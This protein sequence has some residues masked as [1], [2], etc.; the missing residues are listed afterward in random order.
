MATKKSKRKKNVNNSKQPAK[1]SIENLAPPIHVNSLKVTGF[2]MGSAKNGEPLP[3][4]VKHGLTSDDPLFPDI[5]E[6]V[7]RLINGHLPVDPDRVSVD[8]ANCTLVVL[9]KDDSADLW[10]DTAA[11]AF[12]GMTKRAKKA[13]ELVFQ[14]DLA[15][16]NGFD[17]PAVDLQSDDRI[18]CIVRVGW[19]FFLYFDLRTN[20]GLE[21]SALTLELGTLYRRLAY[22]RLY[23]F[24][25]S[26]TDLDKLAAD[27]WFPFAELS[28]EEFQ[29]FIKHLKAGFDISEVG[30]KVIEA[31][32]KERIEALRERWKARPSFASRAGI[33]NAALD[34]YL[35]D[36]YVS[37]IKN[38]VTEIEGLL[39][40]HFGNRKGKIP[41]LIKLAEGAAISKA[42]APDTI[43]LPEK[44]ARYMKSITF[45]GFKSGNPANIASSRHT[46]AHGEAPEATYTKARAL[47]AILTLDQL[48]FYL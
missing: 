4:C 40:D 19:R 25:S 8:Q 43:L 34:A 18:I 27:G 24:V 20:G 10:L 31:F 12:R 36:D 42:G 44:F 41:A 9:H 35:R 33:F 11:I 3:V 6:G 28:F 39:R 1:F 13:G 23:D 16:L 2:A 47:Q 30:N 17:F 37:T 45:A 7:T 48:G 29:H 14:S 15:D 22:A 46:V 21:R 32:D 5:I 38:V 26:Q